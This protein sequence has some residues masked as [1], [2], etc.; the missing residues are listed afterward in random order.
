MKVIL[1]AVALTAL[2]SSAT[3]FARTPATHATVPAAHAAR[4]VPPYGTPVAGETRAEVYH[5]LIRA[6]QDGQLKYL[7][8]TLYAHS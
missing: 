4:W 6:E 1:A 7:D 2:A 3:A 5:D 8:A